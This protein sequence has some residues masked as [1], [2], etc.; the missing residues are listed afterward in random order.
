MDGV[1][2]PS[3]TLV[4]RDAELTEIASLLGVRSSEGEP[5]ATPSLTPNH[6]HSHVVLSGDAGVG[7]TRLLMELRD[8]AQAEGWR[9]VAGHCLDFGDSALP[10][11][12]FSEV[13]GRLE[14][15]LPE[16][17]AKV[18][19]EHPAL[20]RLRPGRRVMNAD[21]DGAEPET[22]DSL[23]RADL[24]T[25]VH[26]LLEA[27]AGLGPLLV[28]V[29]DCH[30]ADQST[31]DLLS[32]LF[33]RSFDGPVEVVASYRSDDLHRRHPLRRQVAEWSRVRGVGRIQLSPL[34]DDDV[35][36]LVAQ[37]APLGLTDRELEAIVGRAE[38]NAFFVEE[39]VGAT[40]DL[41][42]GLP[43]D[44]ADVLL[45]RL[46]RLDDHARQAVR[47]ASVAGRKVAHDLL[48]VTSGLAGP[49]LEEAL[50][51]AVEMNVLV[52]GDG[53]YSFRH[54]LLGEAVYDDLLPGE[55]VRLHAEYAAA[56]ADGRAAGTAA[57][58]ARHA[59]LANDLDAALAAAIRAGDEAAAVGG[60]DEAAQHYQQALE[61]LAD[62][63]RRERFAGDVSKIAV[64]AAVAVTN[65]GQPARAAKLIAEQLAVLPADAS[66][67][68]RSR[69][70]AAR[71]DALF[72]TEPDEDPLSVSQQAV[73]LLPEDATGLRAKVLSIHA[74]ILSGYGRYDDAQAVGLDALAV[75]ERLDL[76]ELVSD[77]VT[78]L[79]GLK[80][81]GPK[82]G[83]RTALADAV[84]RAVATGAVHAELRARHFMGRSYQDWAEYADAER[85]F[86]SAMD[87]AVAA[88]IPWAPY[89]FEGRWQLS[90]VLYVTGKWDEVLELTEVSGEHAPPVLAGLLE[91]VRLLVLAGRGEP[92]AARARGLR[93]HW[94]QEGS[95]AI[96]SAAAELA[97]AARSDDPHAVIDV[98]TDVVALLG[99]IWHE[100]FSA[101]IRLAATTA[102]AVADR[103]PKL[104]AAERASYLEE[105]ER[106]H[107]D[108]H[109]VLQKYSDPSGHWGPEGR[110]WMKRL[111]AETLRVRWLAGTDAPPQDVL[112]EAWRE[113]EQLYA[114]MGHVYELA[115]V[116]TTLAGILRATGDTAGARDVGDAAREVARALGAQPLLDELRSLGSTPSRADGPSDTLTAREAEILALVAEG[117]S[118]GEIGKQL[119]ISAKTVSVHVS[120]IL[121]KLGASGR[122]E[123]AAIAHR[124]G[125]LD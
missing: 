90:W 29:E 33:S 43:D 57:E 30:W 86:R 62:P 67:A 14:A 58:L 61:L 118:N 50:R 117:R 69:M 106:L 40:A 23:D 83:L 6:A 89:G 60:P 3:R 18:A 99:R 72:V 81:A 110:A 56:L 103:M 80:K 21:A 92:T 7:K 51:K 70:L 11:L 100:W 16:L 114:D 37:L 2:Q 52:A 42:Y 104:S 113:A 63:G 47:V 25:A 12:P 73:D 1:A 87:T 17:V 101:R 120:N 49:Q 8:L 102:A 124:R 32:F 93:Q 94:E 75:A 22:S 76:H 28:V 79:S 108:G 55:R 84:E 98:Y 109:T 5:T 4:G 35:R 59:R 95:V 26:A 39:L 54:A 88:G 97:D 71:A 125:L 44:L 91:S 85:W 68:A 74:R 31:R 24:F 96:H 121:G 78:T 105:V 65:A 9:V 27:A 116:R 122:T 111:D 15:E 123:A 19:Y 64:A 41:S 53:R 115:A 119:F 77:I 13:L 38:G 10:Y 34:A 20:S 46:D 36:R 48:A 45:V 82:E 66:P 107:S 112:V